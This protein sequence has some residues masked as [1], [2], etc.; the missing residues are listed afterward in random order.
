MHAPRC[1]FLLDPERLVTLR[2]GIDVDDVVADLLTAW[3]ARYNLLYDD[4]LTPEDLDRWE[5]DQCV[6]KACGKKIFGMLTPDIYREVK[7]IPGA[8]LACEQ[9]RRLGSVF[10][11][12]ACLD[13]GHEVAKFQWLVDH[14]FLAPDEGFR[15]IAVRDT[16]RDV[17][18]DVLLDDKPEHVNEFPGWALLLNR[19]HNRSAKTHRIRINHLGEGLPLLRGLRSP[20]SCADPSGRSR[21]RPVPS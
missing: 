20:C 17:L 7:P 16:K 2:I 11:V 4:A 13:L 18:V 15:F 9:Y 12:S 14:G 8:F 21:P 3:L 6:S 10:F 5:L 1:C 19:P